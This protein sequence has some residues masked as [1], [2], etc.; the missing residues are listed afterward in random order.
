MITL[1]ALPLALLSMQQETGI[2]QRLAGRVPPQIASLVEELG[3]AAS[4]RGL[5]ID[6]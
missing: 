3:T 2:A 1:L 5:P 4:A 6:P